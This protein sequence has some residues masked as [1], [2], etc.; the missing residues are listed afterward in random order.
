MRAPLPFLGRAQVANPIT[1]DNRA[2]KILL[3]RCYVSAP[4]RWEPTNPWRTGT[5]RTV[6]CLWLQNLCGKVKTW[7]YVTLIRKIWNQLNIYK[8]YFRDVEGK[9]SL[10]HTL[11]IGRHVTTLSRIQS[12]IS[13]QITLKEKRPS[14]LNLCLLEVSGWI[15]RVIFLIHTTWNLL[16][17]KARCYI[18]LKSWVEF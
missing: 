11:Q 1:S 8:T 2:H 12:S 9:K 17:G 6:P 10:L 13:L 7:I 3:S 15:S 5:I 16:A 18:L 14:T 4:W